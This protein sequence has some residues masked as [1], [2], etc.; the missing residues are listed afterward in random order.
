MPMIDRHIGAQIQ[1]RRMALGLTRD[2]LAR[3]LRTSPDMVAAYEA[4]ER[5]VPVMA[6]CALAPLFEVELSFFFETALAA[7]ERPAPAATLH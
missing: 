3:A 2:E 4:G 1:T 7:L 5:H 6:L